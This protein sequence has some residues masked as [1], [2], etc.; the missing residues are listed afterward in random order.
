MNVK[1][2]GY[3][4]KVTVDPGFLII[5]LSEANNRIVAPVSIP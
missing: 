1:P 3:Q 5:E 4:V 2:G